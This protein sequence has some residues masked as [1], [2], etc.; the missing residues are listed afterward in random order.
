MINVVVIDVCK[1]KINNYKQNKILCSLEY[2][3]FLLL[4]FFLYGLCCLMK[5]RRAT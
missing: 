5:T 4:C 1:N 3:L 2:H